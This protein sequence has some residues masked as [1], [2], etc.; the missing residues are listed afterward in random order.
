M[1]LERIDPRGLD[2]ATA[3]QIADAMN[4]TARAVGQKV[5]PMT[6]ENL[7]AQATYTH[8]DR[9]YD[10]MWLAREDSR[11]VVGTAWV[12]LP[13]WDNQHLGLAFCVVHPDSWGRGIGTAL[14]DAQAGFAREQGRTML[15]TFCLRDKPAHALLTS[16]GFEV[17]QSQAQRRLYPRELD[18]GRIQTL[19]D[20][21]AAKAGGYELVRLDGPA[22]DD[23]LDELVNI[24][25]AINDAPNDDIEITPDV[26]SV[27]RIRQYESAMS[28][29]RSHLY[30]L[31]ARHRDSGEWAGHTI[32]CVD[33]LRPGM[34]FQEDT[35][36]VARHRGHRLGMWLKATM[37]LWMR[38]LGVDLETI[39]T[40]NA[41]SNAHMIA[42]NDELGCIVNA[43]GL[44]LQL[45][46]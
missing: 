15:L 36:V 25:E 34:A 33:E 13:H 17:G 37:L 39:D 4:A 31:M 44:A 45:H 5:A 2:D 12:E 8:D 9:P 28:H 30:R 14:L 40:W 16:Y 1:D 22:P 6:A 20:D 7:I 10:A 29:R 41:E 32:L 23:W 35:T 26:F 18:Y 46:L 24:F 19:A 21:A 11:E 27:E 42:V 38:D 43:R 3:S